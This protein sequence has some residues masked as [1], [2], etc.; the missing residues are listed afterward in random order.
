MRAVFVDASYFIAQF[1]PGDQWEE[2]AQEARSRLG[3]VELVTTDEILT[4]F[5][6]GISRGGAAIREKA[7][8]AV[9]EILRDG[10]IRVIPQTR[11]SFLDGLDRFRRRL[12][13]G[14]SIQDCIAMNVMEAEGITEILTSDHHFEQE[15]FIVLM[16]PVP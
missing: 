15:G 11:P 2:L 7:V 5:L 4:E 1:S 12:D 6:T 13:K 16:K 9:Q 3:D 14:Y 8:V 10:E